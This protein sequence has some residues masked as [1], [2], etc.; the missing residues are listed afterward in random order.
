MVIRELKTHHALIILLFKM[1]SLTKR[2]IPSFSFFISSILTM[3]KR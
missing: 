2:K 3:S 1:E